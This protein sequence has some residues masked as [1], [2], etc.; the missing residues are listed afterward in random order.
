MNCKFRL[1]LSLKK[2]AFEE[3]WYSGLSM[4]FV[5]GTVRAW[6]FAAT[7]NIQVFL[8]IAG[9]SLYNPWDAPLRPPWPALH[10]QL[11]S[12]SLSVA[13]KH[14][15]QAVFCALLQPK[16]KSQVLGLVWK[17]RAQLPWVGLEA[18]DLTVK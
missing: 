2:K 17:T 13:S 10:L 3:V 8:A 15:F 12:P 16:T 7:F 11:S 6:S 9:S 4:L 1:S 18:N 5:S 14:S